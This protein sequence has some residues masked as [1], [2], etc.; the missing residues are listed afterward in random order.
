M[1]DLWNEILPDDFIQRP[2]MSRIYYEGKFYSYPLRAF[3]ALNNLGIL[4]STACMAS[5]LWSKLFPIKDVRSF[6]DWTSN[7]FG[8]KLYSIFFKTYTEKVWGMPCN[9]MSADWAAQRI[10]GLS[11][12]GAVTDG[13]QALARAQQ[14][15]QRRAGGQDAARDLP[16]PAPRPGHDVGCRAR[17]GRRR[18]ATR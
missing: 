1:V 3:E 13:L 12:W 15:A 17:Q 2:R 8:K 18:A 6:E 16:L 4:R 10:K 5:Y 11:L 7:Q 9:E 14:A